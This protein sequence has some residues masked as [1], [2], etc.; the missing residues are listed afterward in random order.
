M[1][2]QNL[3]TTPPS[4]PVLREDTPIEY[5]HID[6]LLQNAPVLKDG[7]PAVPLVMEDV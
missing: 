7:C 4:P 6:K 5:P 3:P 2:E 1:N